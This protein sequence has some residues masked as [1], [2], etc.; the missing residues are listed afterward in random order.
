[1]DDEFD[2]Q[3][4]GIGALAEPSRRALYLYVASQPAAVGREQVA[5]GV[6]LPLHSVKFHLD[7]LVEEG[8]LDVEFR[9]LSDRTG[10]GAGRPAKLY[11]RSTRQLAVSLPQRRYELA[12]EVLAEA[13][14]RSMRDHITLSDAIDDSA[15]AEGRRIAAD[16]SLERANTEMERA[17][18]VLDRHGYE[19]RRCAKEIILNNCPFDSL[20]QGHTQLVCTMNLS[21]IHGVLDGLGCTGLEAVLAPEPGRCCVKTRRRR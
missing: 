11:R 3:L 10:P 13:I 12:G 15:R 17:V 6:Q 2:A 16:A 20:A 8:L 4:S 5:E 18:T 1:M 19:P 21:L 9:R 14:D 7:R